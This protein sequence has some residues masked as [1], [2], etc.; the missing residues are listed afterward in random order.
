MTNMTDSEFEEAL[1]YLQF[2]FEYAPYRKEIEERYLA[3]QPNPYLFHVAQG[4]R[5]LILLSFARL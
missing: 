4:L 3:R 1:E 2:T 5:P